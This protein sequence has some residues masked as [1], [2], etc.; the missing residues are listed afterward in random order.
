[1]IKGRETTNRI[2]IAIKQIRLFVQ[3]NFTIYDGSVV[4][5]NH[6]TNSVV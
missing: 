5:M 1:M 4:T 2:T 6:Q 3:K